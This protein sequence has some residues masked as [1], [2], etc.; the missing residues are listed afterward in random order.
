MATM[1]C[2][3]VAKDTIHDS[4]GYKFKGWWKWVEVLAVQCGTACTARSNG[5]FNK[6]N[7]YN[8]QISMF[9]HA[10]AIWIYNSC[11]KTF[12]VFMSFYYC[13]V[14]I[15]SYYVCY[16]VRWKINS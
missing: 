4:F 3:E 10:N 12:N 7:I 2:F 15:F 1:S 16:C 9:L 6:E 11:C 5:G 13:F 14:L 8:I